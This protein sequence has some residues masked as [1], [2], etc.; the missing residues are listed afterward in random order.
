M[1]EEINPYSSKAGDTM[2]EVTGL[3]R[4]RPH[5]ALQLTV[6]FLKLN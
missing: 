4:Q 6:V 2:V 1:A 5:S 3:F